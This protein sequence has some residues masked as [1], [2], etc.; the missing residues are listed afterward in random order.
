MK[1]YQKWSVLKNQ[2]GATAV[3][4]GVSMFALVGFA[5]LVV[6]LGNLYVARN[7]LQ[8]AADA[9]ALAGAGNL[10]NDSGTA[11]NSSANAD[12]YNVAKANFSQNKSVDVN[13][14][15]GTN[16]VDVQ[17]GHWSFGK[18]T[19]A[20][21]FTANESLVLTD[22]WNVTT[23]ELDA[24]PNFI[25]A[26]RVVA[27]RQAT[28]VASFFAKIFGYNNFEVEAEAVGYIGFSGKLAPG[29]V[30][31]PI[32]I[33]KDSILNNNNEYDCTIGRM[34]NSGQDAESNETGGWTSFNQDDNPCAGGTNADDLKGLVC[35]DGNPEEIF[36]GEPME[37]TGGDLQVVFN[38][39]ID[40]WVKE[41]GTTQPWTLT[42]PVIDCGDANNVGTC[43]EV[44]GAVV[45]NIIWI[46]GGG[47]DPL[48]KNAPKVMNDVPSVD[49]WS[50]STHTGVLLADLEGGYVNDTYAEGTLVEQVFDTDGK[51]RWASFVQ[52]FNLLNNDGT[53]EGTPAPYVKK[54]IYF[55]PDCTPHI[56]TGTS[57]GENFGGLAK[58]PVLVH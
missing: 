23:A 33:C 56:P 57:G 9:G 37:T 4:V 26:V 54:S 7:E 5:A 29:D 17:R 47:E 52:Y 8:N 12:A 18:S 10:Y 6:D 2:R 13:W 44:V 51:V 32:A 16:G 36:L 30:D 39:L 42:L 50:I 58:I 27:R 53:P 49:D 14:T 25:N 35:A 3:I 55:L 19:L 11:I 34:I 41:T 46:T 48:Y 15:P 28:P 45:L 24:D 1:R 31:Q 21:G 20:N 38:Q 22:L 40:C 43:A